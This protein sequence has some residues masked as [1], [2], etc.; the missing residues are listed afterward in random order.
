[1]IQQIGRRHQAEAGIIIE[2]DEG[3]HRQKADGEK[4]RQSFVAQMCGPGV[5]MEGRIE[6]LARREAARGGQQQNE[7]DRGQ[8]SHAAERA[9]RHPPGKAL[10]Q[11]ARQHPARHAAERIAADQQPDSEAESPGI[12]LFGQIG[13]RDRRHPAHQQ[14]GQG[15]RRQK[16][17]PVW[18]EGAGDGQKRR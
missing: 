14:S 10:H 6:A 3:P 17:G 7:A 18:R 2:T 13:H 12:D 11:N 5:K 9:Q 4:R 1:L 8:Q 16:H 15:A